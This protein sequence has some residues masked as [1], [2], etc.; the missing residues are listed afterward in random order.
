MFFVDAAISTIEVLTSWDAVAISCVMPLTVWI[1]ADVSCIADALSPA[2]EATLVVPRDTCSIDAA[3]SLIDVTSD[4]AE[5]VTEDAWP[6][7]SS[8]DAAIWLMLPSA[9]SS[10]RICESA[11]SATSSVMRTMPEADIVNCSACERMAPASRLSVARWTFVPFIDLRDCV[12]IPFSS[13]S[14]RDER[15]GDVQQFC[16]VQHQDQAVVDRHDPFD[17]AAAHAGHRILRRLDRARRHAQ[18]LAPVVGDQADVPA[19][20]L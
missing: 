3:S 4:S 17:I 7:G 2:D 15:L 18:E 19:A 5:P 1:E 9:S 14:R 11:P 20:R 12:A 6:A 13:S 10:D 16:Q 8:S